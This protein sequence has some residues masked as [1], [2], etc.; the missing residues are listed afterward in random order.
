MS[1]RRDGSTIPHDCA[2]RPRVTRSQGAKPFR[3]RGFYPGN[4]PV[5][6][7]AQEDHRRHAHTGRQGRILPGAM[8]MPGGSTSG[9]H[10]VWR[11]KYCRSRELRVSPDPRSSAATFRPR[12]VQASESRL[13]IRRHFQSYPLWLHDVRRSPTFCC[14]GA[15]DRIEYRGLTRSAALSRCSVMAEEPKGPMPPDAQLRPAVL[16]SHRL[17]S[18]T[19]IL[20]AHATFTGRRRAPPEQHRDQTRSGPGRG[21][22][23]RTSEHDPRA[24]GPNHRRD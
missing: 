5:A 3:T 13:R 8:R 19:P 15:I 11:E 1:S 17:R 6:G 22:I 10:G 16:A 12:H 18:G 24:Q 9:S 2:M 20:A 4:D 21:E 7:V 23:D 14:L